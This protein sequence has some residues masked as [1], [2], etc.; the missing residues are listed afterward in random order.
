MN[1]PKTIIEEQRFDEIQTWMPTGQGTELPDV[2]KGIYFM[3]GNKLPDDC[4]T[5]NAQWDA[6]RLTLFIRVFDPLQW[7]FN[8]S[9]SGRQLLKLIQLTRLV[10]EIRFK[11]NTF[12]RADA[13]P[14]ILGFRLPRW[15]VVFEMNQTE[16]SVDGSTWD[17]RNRGFFRLI[18]MGGYI[19]RKI[20]DKNG[21]K[22]STFDKM[23]SQVEE[24]C[25]VVAEPE[26]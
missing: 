26:S 3:D 5:M 2:L 15:I 8:P 9:D 21:Q 10:Y 18:P 1:Q 24:T 11:D 6:E 12:K 17:R 20:V 16:D 4:F 25:I 19:L 23:L 14:T 22:L 13:I 7:T